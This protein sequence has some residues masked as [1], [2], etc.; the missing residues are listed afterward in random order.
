MIFQLFLYGLPEREKRIA[1]VQIDKSLAQDLGEFIHS[2]RVGS[3]AVVNYGKA[4]DPAI[5]RP[6]H[7]SPYCA[8]SRS[9]GNPRASS[10]RLLL[11]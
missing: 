7:G 5:R 3:E 10:A 4:V 8:G 11:E 1:P 2:G 9:A 6:D